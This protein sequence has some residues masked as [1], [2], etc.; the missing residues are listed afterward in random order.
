MAH[1]IAHLVGL[2]EV[3]GKLADLVLWKPAFSGVK[4]N[5]VLKSGMAVSASIGDMGVRSRRAAGA[6]PPHGAAT[7]RRCASVAFVSQVSLSNPAV[8][9][10]GLNKRLEAVRGCR[11]A[12]ARHG[13]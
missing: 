4:V 6:D 7:A 8:S 9:E 13:G 12:Q 10:L 2:V 1:G 11:G 3:R 5:M